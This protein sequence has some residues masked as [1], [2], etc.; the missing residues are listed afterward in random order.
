MKVCVIFHM[1]RLIPV[2]E[3]HSSHLFDEIDVIVLTEKGIT[4]CN[5]SCI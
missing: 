1:T 5:I 2:L 4:V 3:Y